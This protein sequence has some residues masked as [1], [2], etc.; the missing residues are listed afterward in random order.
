MAKI[1]LTDG[2]KSIDRVYDAV[3]ENQDPHDWQRQHLGASVMGHRCERYL[4][5][6]YHWA[7]H[8]Q[9]DGRQLN[10][11]ERGKRAEKWIIHDLRRAG[12]VV[13][14]QQKKATGLPP[15]LGGS[16]DGIIEGLVESKESHLL[17]IKTHSVKSFDYLEKN[18]VK[19]AKPEHWIQM[20]VY[21]R[22]LK[23]NRAYYLAIC[24]NDDR[25][26]PERVRFDAEAADF[27]IA[28]AA[29]ITELRHPPEK[30]DADNAPCVLVSNEGKRYPCQFFDL[31]HG[32]R[33]PAKNCRTCMFGADADG[34]RMLCRLSE[35]MVTRN[36]Q[37]TGCG[38]HQ[39]LPSMVNAQC[40]LRITEPNIFH[41][42]DGTQVV[43]RHE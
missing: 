11:F 13:H 14:S 8:P 21:M 26:Y 16:I 31:C 27:A 1:D 15:R 5:L 7:A 33:M 34:K 23:L 10:L 25:L 37:V 35:K 24:K 29:R 42:A 4:W 19:R 6:T 41:F 39:T 40:E 17:E 36:V 32:K 12:F 38:K 43:D 9:H 3:R 2:P 20:Q 30:L 18:G 22:A 28:R